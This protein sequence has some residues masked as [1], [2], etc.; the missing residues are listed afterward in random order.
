MLALVPNGATM[1]IWTDLAKAR[2]SPL[3]RRIEA[4]SR[5]RTLAGCEISAEELLVAMDEQGP[6]AW[7]LR[8]GDATRLERCGSLKVRRVDRRTVVL[9]PERTARRIPAQSKRTGATRRRTPL[10]GLLCGVPEG[11]AVA[12]AAMVGQKARGRLTAMPALKDSGSLRSVVGSAD[13]TDG[14]RVSLRARLGSRRAAANVA[15]GIERE[16]DGWRRQPMVLLAGLLPVLA[17]IK[18]G[19]DGDETTI[20]AGMNA[21]TLERLI[22]Q[23][24]VLSGTSSRRP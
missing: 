16:I 13:L 10:A 12:F 15:G 18:V 19:A 21:A 23:I 2:S 7:V 14:L 24:E 11:R 8:G 1:A 6:T 4:D 3:V 20:Q 22:Q 9:A 17:D 5:W